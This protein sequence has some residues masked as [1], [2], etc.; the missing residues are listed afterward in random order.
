MK[1]CFLDAFASASGNQSVPEPGALGLLCVG[2]VM[3]AL[4]VRQVLITG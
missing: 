1:R 2:S 3:T 4:V